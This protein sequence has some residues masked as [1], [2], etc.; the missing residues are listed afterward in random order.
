M[1]PNEVSKVITIQKKFGDFYHDF[2]LIPN[3]SKPDKKL[4]VINE[5][6]DSG[7]YNEL[8]NENIKYE[9]QL[10]I[11]FHE[12]LYYID[13]DKFFRESIFK[14]EGGSIEYFSLFTSKLKPK[15]SLLLMR[16]M[17]HYIFRYPRWF[18]EKGTNCYDS[19]LSDPLFW[20]N[21]RSP[22]SDYKNNKIENLN[23]Q[24][25]SF[26]AKTNLKK[27]YK[28]DKE[29]SEDEI[30]DDAYFAEVKHVEYIDLDKQN[31]KD[32]KDNKELSEEDKL[33][34]GRDI[35]K[36]EVRKSQKDVQ[37]LLLKEANAVLELKYKK[38]I[39]ILEKNDNKD[40]KDNKDNNKSKIN[41]S[42]LKSSMRKVDT[43]KENNNYNK[44]S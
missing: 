6:L 38:N 4:S 34:S 1:Y 25:L 29:S 36:N 18:W 26:R 13:D 9:E 20:V 28:S 5:E 7:I 14:H 22:G 27:D 21:D 41:P 33:K 10:F 23:E 39:E 12:I 31:N 30:D 35:L 2:F 16:N 19:Y 37:K 32:N 42:K 15:I 24:K 11:A 44:S 8:D 43:K 40:N 3:M 17:M